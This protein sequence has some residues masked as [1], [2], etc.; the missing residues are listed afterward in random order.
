NPIPF[1][2]RNTTWIHLTPKNESELAKLLQKYD[3]HPLTIEDILNPHSR[4]KMEKFPNYTFFV[5]RG[6]HFENNQIESRNFNFLIT[7]N[8]LITIVIDHRNTIEDIITEWDSYKQLLLKGPEFI[9]HRIIDV[10]TDHIF[11]IIYKI[12]D[13]AE[14]IEAQ[15]FNQTAKL[16]INS[17]FVMR[18]NL[19]H[20]KKVIQRHKE[21]LDELEDVK[22]KFF[23]V[24]S[25]AFFRDVRDHSLR[26]L[27]S[28]ESIK[29]MISS[30]LEVHLTISTRRSNEIMKILTI[31]T[32]IMLPMT[33]IAGIYGMNFEHM[34]ELQSKYGYYFTLA[35]MA[36][37]GMGMALYFKMKRWFASPLFFVSS[38]ASSFTIESFLEF[39][40]LSG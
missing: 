21:I 15:V 33:L 40:I 22:T 1:F 20:I 10:E 7:K 27:E 36:T 14:A 13:Q 19:Q 29:E 28:A 37:L 6:L 3:I 5:F 30:A 8:T 18:G 23:S 9:V 26:I 12:E 39:S 16:D 34:P 2:K 4:I 31:M 24:E 32:A 11:P 25:E 17:I 38:S 35:G